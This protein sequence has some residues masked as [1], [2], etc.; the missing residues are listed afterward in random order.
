MH[1]AT[2]RSALNAFD[3]GAFRALRFGAGVSCPRC[4]GHRIHRWGRSR[5]R[6]RYRC[7][8]CGRTFN[9]F[10]GTPLAYLKRVD[11]VPEYLRCMDRSMP[12]RATGLQL[13]IDPSTAFRWRHRFLAA[14]RRGDR[15]PFYGEVT[16]GFVG[17]TYSDKG[18]RMAEPRALR[19]TS[20]LRVPVL[21]ALDGVGRVVS[22]VAGL[23]RVELGVLTRL[24]RAHSA[25]PTSLAT[26][27]GPYAPLGRWSALA[28][29][30]CR[31]VSGARM[32]AIGTYGRQV[33]RWLA[34]FR[35]VATRYLDH[36]LTWYELVGGGTARRKT[37][38]VSYG[39]LAALTSAPPLRAPEAYGA[40]S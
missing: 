13:G 19:G 20:P 12:V 23:D 4:D 25:L 36:Y 24:L 8:H 31:R 39:S 35:G 26:S 33:K 37:R 18:R 21:V 5:N 29:I 40:V 34:R 15:Y 7:L 14:W 32:E 10:T 27:A 22:G 38:P 17:F 1:S 3:F 30:P 6:C 9:D 11:L 2:A 16:A 28:G